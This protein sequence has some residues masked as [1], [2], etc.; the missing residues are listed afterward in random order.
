MNLSQICISTCILLGLGLQTTTA[1][2]MLDMDVRSS[3]ANQL[4]FSLSIDIMETEL[5][6]AT[7]TTKIKF[8]RIGINSFDVPAE[9]VQLG[10][11][12][13]YAYTSQDRIPA[14]QGLDLNG[15]YLGLGMRLPMLERQYF[16]ALLNADYIYQSV[17]GARSGQDASRYW[18]EYQAG[19]TLQSHIHPLLLSVGLNYTK[20]DATQEA[21][22]DI[23]ETL[24]LDNNTHTQILF[25]VN[26]LLNIDEQ[27]GLHFFSG[28]SQGI[29]FLFQ[30]MFH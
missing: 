1:S 4:D 3:R 12:I 18:H 16:R 22:G 25:G 28:T 2:A 26:Y 23:Q 6:S 13:G 30:K 17:N 20:I 11:H 10:G 7:T 29:G 15:Y 14:T 27:V 5:S 21:N 24:F 8:R 9:G 19:L